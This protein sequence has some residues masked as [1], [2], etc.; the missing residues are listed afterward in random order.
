MVNKNKDIIE[1][2]KKVYS[3]DYIVK[4]YYKFKTKNDI[5]NHAFGNQFI[6]TRKSIT[7]EKA[8]EDV[9]EAIINYHKHNCTKSKYF[10]QTTCKLT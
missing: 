3:I 5:Q 8:R 4:N 10:A 9:E 6:I 1:L 2:Y 7:M